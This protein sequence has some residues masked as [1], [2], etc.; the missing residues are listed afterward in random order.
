MIRVARNASGNCVIFHGQTNPTYFNACLTAE[1]VDADY[2]SI[3][4][5]IAT[6][7]GDPVYEYFRIHFSEWQHEDFSIFSSAQDAVDYINSIGNVTDAVGTGTSFGPEDTLDFT[8]EETNTSILLDNGDH[9]GVNGLKAVEK[10]NG[11]VGIETMLGGVEWYE[12]D[13]TGVTINGASAG[14][15]LSTVV[16][17]LNAL[18]TVSAVGGVVP[19]PVYTMDGGTEIT[20]NA[21][22]TI[23]PAGDGLHGNGTTG[24]KYHGPRV[25]TTETINE[26]GEYFTFEAKNVVAGGGPLL[27]I[28][29]YSVT[30]GDLTELQAT[31]LSNSGH[32]GYFFSTWLYNYSGYSAPWT[33]YGSH[34]TLSYGPGWN[35]AAASQF[36]YSDAHDSFRDN[37]TALLRCGITDEGFVGIWYY[38]VEVAGI[39][40]AYG[41]RSN[42][43]ILLARS[44]TPVPA[45]EYGLMVKI[46]TTSGQIMSAPTRFATDA[47][48][49]TLHYRYIESP[50]GNFEFPLFASAEEAEYVSGDSLHDEMMYADDTTPGTVWY[51][52]RTGFTNNGT[53]APADTSEIIYTLIPTQDDSNFV[54]AAFGTQTLTVDEGDVL[55]YQLQPADTSYVTTI[56]GSLPTG[57]Q[58]TSD[59]SLTGTAP[60]V[61]GDNVTNPSDD[62][63]VTVSRTNG[64]GTSTGTLTVTV[65]NLTAPTVD[66]G[67]FTVDTGSIVAGVLQEDSLADLSMTI[68]EGDRVIVPKEWVDA[69]VQ[70]NAIGLL[71][72]VFMGVLKSGTNTDAITLGD[73]NCCF[74]WEG[75]SSTSSH[76]VRMDDNVGSSTSNVTF[77]NSGASIYDYA[78]EVYSGDLWLIACNMNALNT[79]PAAGNGGSFSRTLNCGPLTDNGLTSPF[80]IKV[81]TYAGTLLDLDDALTAED[82]TKIS[83]PAAPAGIVTPWTK[84]LDFSGSSERTQMATSNSYWHPMIMGQTGILCDLPV[85]SG[86]TSAHYAARPWATACVFQADRNSSNQHIWNMGDGAGNLDDNIYLRLDANGQVYFG[87]GRTG[88]LNEC[89]VLNIPSSATN[90]WYGVYVASNGARLSGSDATAANLADAFDIRVMSSEGGDN[91]TTLGA[92]QS[93]SSNWVTTGGRMD[94]I[95]SGIMTVGGRGANRNFH[96]KVA[97]FVTTSLRQTDS[98][99]SNTEIQAIISDPVEWLTDYKIGQSFRQASA[100]SNTSNFTLNQFDSSGSTQIWLMGDGPNDSYSN[101]IR[102]ITY[103][104][105]QNYTKLN[106]VSMV[107]NDIQTVTI[108]GLS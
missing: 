6:G 20:W 80:T 62:V 89:E 3:R 52:P 70:P 86:D 21:I 106:M 48:A 64:F 99:P 32:H 1:V 5:D 60:E 51:A 69:H 107:S 76:Y 90:E 91:F 10:S 13:H 33:T 2:V 92:N 83:I 79:E 87:W 74:R 43:W 24:T 63:I 47:A 4:N 37:G 101:M 38:D 102:N 105:D 81:G 8:R 54:P 82:I 98:M 97:S 39:D 57:W 67:D 41:A 61:T 46:P 66:T 15:T 29:L 65:N 40:S 44:G 28:G 59:G 31:G 16:N 9:H 56:G 77:S 55:N 104:A 58:V 36:R 93:T 73:F 14:N 72:K 84:A 94:R 17:A 23:D 50:D 88:A 100:T 71:E 25:Y 68:E 22:D 35:G 103:N 49:P 26:P 108:P 53:A 19:A 85:S 42:N 12:L 75:L 45:G 7:T 11:R 27:G 78:F 18:F 34:S 96:G 30:N 95:F